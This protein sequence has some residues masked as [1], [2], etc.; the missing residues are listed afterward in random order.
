[1]A[2]PTRT[3][4]R[5]WKIVLVCSLALNMA[6]AG[7]VI[8][9]VSSGR[10]GDGPPR[11][12]DLGIGPISRALLPQEQRDVRRA[13]REN[14]NLRN[15]DFRGDVRNIEAALLTEPFSADALREA[16][17][18]QRD[19]MRNVQVQAQDALIATIAEMTPERRTAFADKLINEMSRNRQRGSRDG[20]GG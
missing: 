14:G 7:V 19:R 4:S 12:F 13:M 10:T 20:S 15:L 17:S 11:S 6:V 8:G 9:A 2:D 16:L 3:P 18:V 1:M 5:L